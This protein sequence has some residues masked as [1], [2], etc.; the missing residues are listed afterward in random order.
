MTEDSARLNY[1]R[2]LHGRIRELLMRE[3][4]PIGVAGVP[5]A[6]DEY[7]SYVNGVAR[8]LIRRQSVSA[9]HEYLWQ[10]ETQQMGL[11]GDPVRTRRV[12]AHLGSLVDAS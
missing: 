2:G 9:I 4:D 12:A 8:L 6:A 10:A 7:D 11:C 3:W 5:E 1:A